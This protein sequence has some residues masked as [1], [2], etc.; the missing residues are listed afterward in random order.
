MNLPEIITTAA[1]GKIT[2]E[3]LE[4]I[5][6]L[7][8]TSLSGG[9]SAF[10]QWMQLRGNQRLEALV[11]RVQELE[12]ENQNLQQTISEAEKLSPGSAHTKTLH[13]YITTPLEEKV[14]LL[15]NALQNGLYGN[16][17]LEQREDLYKIVHVLQPLDVLILKCLVERCPNLL[18]AESLLQES[19]TN[20]GIQKFES[21]RQV[22]S[23]TSIAAEFKAVPHSQIRRALDR[24]RSQEL[25][26]NPA[27]G[28][29]FHNPYDACMPM[30]MAQTFLNFVASPNLQ[31]TGN[32]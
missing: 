25:I 30:E 27:P 26:F 7:L 21:L 20:E 12:A 19:N 24:L 8:Q 6:P 13:E 22:T 9:P 14:E 18:Q 15:R 5:S 1:I 23:F 29:D 2:V 11:Q 4:K 31:P 32:V 10:D 16:Y 28:F 17:T 3:T